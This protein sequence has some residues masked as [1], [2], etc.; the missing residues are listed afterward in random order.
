MNRHPAQP[1][2]GDPQIDDAVRRADPWPRGESPAMTL[3]LEHL[4]DEILATPGPQRSSVRPLGE[5]LRRRLV[6]AAA[7]GT[8]AATVVGVTVWQAN[9]DAT[10]PPPITPG[11]TDTPRTHYSKLLLAAAEHAPRLL[12][13]RPG[14]SVVEVDGFSA[15]LGTVVMGDGQQYLKLDW[16]PADQY[17]SLHRKRVD[18]LPPPEPVVVAGGTADLFEYSDT[19]FEAVLPPDGDTFAVLRIGP[20]DKQ[21]TLGLL[22]SVK[23]VGVTQW[24][25]AM[26]A[27]VVKPGRSSDELR[28]VLAGVP[29][30]PGIDT[31]N[32]APEGVYDRY[33][34][35]AEVTKPIVCGWI[36]QWIIAR[37]QGAPADEQRA[38]DALDS[39]MSWEVLKDMTS[40]GGYP[41]V[42]WEMVADVD[43]GRVP[44]G[45]PSALGCS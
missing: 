24:L 22:A 31:A 29:I 2:P 30:P 1:R 45:Y 20:A 3:A 6:T 26:P 41:R 25:D 8:A 5:I 35:G 16:Y 27:D 32:L 21:T 42:V 33:Q 4:C 37:E 7:L 19:S 43:Q 11:R 36:E 18:E 13:D 14:W 23:G 12:V 34:F 17:T 9:D 38:Q 15:D 39:S 44:D 40:E 10:V 28:R